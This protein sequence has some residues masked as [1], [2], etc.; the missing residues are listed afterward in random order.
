MGIPTAPLGTKFQYK[1]FT[2]EVLKKC[3]CN[4]SVLGAWF[5]I[6]CKTFHFDATLRDRHHALYPDH[7]HIWWCEYHGPQVP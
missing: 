7:K 4:H 2:L 1:N 3:D 6:P 5:C